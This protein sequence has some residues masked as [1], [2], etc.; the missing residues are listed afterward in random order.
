MKRFAFVLM[1]LAGVMTMALADS[2]KLDKAHSGVNFAVTHMVI[3]E[4]TGNFRDFSINL[5]SS[6]EDFSGSS[7]DATIKVGSINT[8]QERRDDHLKSEDFFNAE[9]FPEINFKST[10]IEKVSEKQYKIIGDM[11]I[12]GITKKVTFDAVHGGTLNT[13]Q[14]TISGW[15]A[16]TKINR[17]DFGLRWNRAV[18]A[19]GVLVGEIV[20]ITL[21]LKFIKD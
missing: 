10:S 18:E 7:I 2:W 17:Y 15:K 5:T 14:G 20:D 12:R 9:Q 19:G 16:T 1:T 13:Q 11:T 3:S 21:N 4:V 8:D 6:G